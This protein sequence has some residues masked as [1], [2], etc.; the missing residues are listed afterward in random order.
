MKSLPYLHTSGTI[1]WA[2]CEGNMF[3]AVKPAL[4]IHGNI[5]WYEERASHLQPYR[6][7][8]APSVIDTLHGI[9][10]FSSTSTSA[11]F[12]SFAVAGIFK[13]IGEKISLSH[14]V[15]QAELRHIFWSVVPASGVV[16]GPSIEAGSQWFNIKDCIFE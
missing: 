5:A 13:S 2:D 3:R 4:V 15:S 8:D 14:Q 6:Y 12:K 11:W 1:A 9:L 10:L 7:A 16:Y